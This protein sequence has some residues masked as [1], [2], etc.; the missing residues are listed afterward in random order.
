M[1]FTKEEKLLASLE[2]L[3]TFVNAFTVFF[4]W[5]AANFPEQFYKCLSPF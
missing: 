1:F 4:S 3:L 2:K 5:P